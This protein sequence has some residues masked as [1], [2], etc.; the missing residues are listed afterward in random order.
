MFRYALLHLGDTTAAEDVVQ[1][2]LLAGLEAAGKFAGRSSERTWLIGILRHKVVDH[3][4]A[5][6]RERP[7][8]DVGETD[9]FIAGL[10]AESGLWKVGP[11]KWGARADHAFENREFWDV[12][13]EC[14]KRLPA[15]MAAA[16]SLRELDALNA[17]ETCKLLGV[18]ATNLWAMLHR[19]RTRLRE[20][21]EE[22]WFG[23]GGRRG[24]RK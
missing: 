5:K 8:G 15:R 1:E 14:R 7:A 17:D 11:Q 20:C 6:L 3:L 9:P 19:A 18:S 24:E 13:N 4:R 21:L 23:P 10:F 22:K 2:A 16:F 12:F